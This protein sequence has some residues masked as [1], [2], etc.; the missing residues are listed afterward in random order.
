MPAPLLEAR[1]LVKKFPGVVALQNVNFDLRAG[2]VHALC[3]ENGAGKTNL[4]EA[5]SLL[6]PGRG[7]RGARTA[8]FARQSPEGPRP[9]VHCGNFWLPC[10]SAPPSGGLSSVVNW[11]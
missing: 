6:G 10:G 4:L 1:D 3:G 7:M 5:I 9:S 2:E 11:D 8:E